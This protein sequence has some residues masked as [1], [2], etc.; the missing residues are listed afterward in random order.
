MPI[1]DMTRMVNKGGEIKY[2]LVHMTNSIDG[3]LLMNDNMLK[4]NND[5]QVIQ[6]ELFKVDVDH[7]DVDSAAIV[8]DIQAAIESLPAGRSV[9][10]GVFAAGIINAYGV[11][12][13]TTVLLKTY[14]GPF[15][16][17]GAIVR[18]KP[19]TPTHKPSQSFNPKERVHRA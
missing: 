17:S 3:C 18:D 13:R 19:F 7:R 11:F 10:M 14:L 5:E 16:D 6:H 4:R 9:K 2:R 1:K 15:L 8:Q 12:D